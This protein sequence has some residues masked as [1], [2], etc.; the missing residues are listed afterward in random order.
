MPRSSRRVRRPRERADR[1]HGGPAHA[2]SGPRICQPC[3]VH[4]EGHGEH[5]RDAVK[6]A[7]SDDVPVEVCG[8]PCVASGRPN[9]LGG[10][11]NECLLPTLQVA[12][13]EPKSPVTFKI[14]ASS[15]PAFLL[16]TDEGPPLAPNAV[17]LRHRHLHGS[18]DASNGNAFITSPARKHDSRGI[19]NMELIRSVVIRTSI[20]SVSNLVATRHEHAIRGRS[21]KIVWFL[22]DDKHPLDKPLA[23]LAHPGELFLHIHDH[24][25]MQI[26]IHTPALEWIPVQKGVLIRALRI[27]ASH[28][29]LQ[30]SPAWVTKDTAR[31]YKSR[32]K[33]CERD[34]STPS[35]STS[36]GLLKLHGGSHISGPPVCS[37]RASTPDAI[38]DSGSATTNTNGHSPCARPRVSPGA[39]RDPPH[40]FPPTVPQCTHASSALTASLASMRRC[41]VC[42]TRHLHRLD[43]HAVPGGQK[44]AGTPTRARILGLLD[45]QDFQDRLIWLRTETPST[46]RTR[47]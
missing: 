32:G 2:D 10:S 38:E 1:I 3:V 4:D 45:T 28:F 26:W 23:V 36:L 42:Q 16:E 20:A 5:A 29:C 21:E 13:I 43:M 14:K 47:R 7:R 31:T 30:E 46:I 19:R 11:F 6:V 22:S 44:A 35:R 8:L 18:Y 39:A 27:C 37:A 15:S 40:G 9:G 17:I 24:H 34:L 41:C 25:L 12:M 33:K